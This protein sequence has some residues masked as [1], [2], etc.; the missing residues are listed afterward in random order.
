MAKYRLGDWLERRPEDIANEDRER[1]MAIDFGPVIHIEAGKRTGYIS[2]LCSDGTQLTKDE[3][4][5]RK[6]RRRHNRKLIY[7]TVTK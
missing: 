7:L 3:D 6:T 4:G 5:F 1:R 2:I